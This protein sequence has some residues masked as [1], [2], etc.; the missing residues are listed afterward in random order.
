MR[1]LEL[2]GGGS[3][4]VLGQGT[5][6]MGDDA[7]KRVEEIRAL[8]TGIDLGLTLIDTAEMY[9]NGK[10]ETL[11]GEAIAGRRDQVFLVSKVLPS[12]ASRKGTRAACE[13]S[14]KRLRT[15]VIDLYLLHWEGSYPF[16]ETVAGMADLLEAGKIR[17]WGVSNLDVA[18]MEEFFSLPGGTAC[19]VNQVLYNLSRRGV[20]YNLLPWCLERSLPVMAYSPVEQGRILTNPSLKRV[21]ERLGATPAQT[22]LAW[23]LERPGV[24]AIPKA[25]TAAHVAENAKSLDITLSARDKAELDA[26]FPPPACRIPLQML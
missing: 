12:N 17:H 25:G 26:A 11:V 9:G 18:E 10:S 24:M 2:S 4:P 22:A 1:T 3:I 15:D 19:A 7:R 16:E 6:Y 5:W 23:V 8:Q 14:L 13:N 21:A 20:E